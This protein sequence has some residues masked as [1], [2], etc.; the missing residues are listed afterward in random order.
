MPVLMELRLEAALPEAVRGPVDFCELRR[1]A[2][3][4]S[5][6]RIGLL[7]QKVADEMA[8]LGSGRAESTENRGK[9]Y[10]FEA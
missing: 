7:A 1:L 5:W 4:W 8:G 6:E 3:I 10:F 9:K 2:S